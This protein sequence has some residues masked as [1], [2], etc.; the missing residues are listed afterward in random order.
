MRS[1]RL[2]GAAMCTSALALVMVSAMTFA[3]A[4]LFVA[5]E[6]EFRNEAAKAIAA[7][8][9]SRERDTR[10]TSSRP[11]SIQPNRPAELEGASLLPSLPRRED[12]YRT[13]QTVA[14]FGLI[15]RR[16]SPC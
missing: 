2:A 12:T 5:D 6:P 7:A 8:G 11:A 13:V 4:P 1:V 15:S 14:L 9:G 3:I 16:P 10:S